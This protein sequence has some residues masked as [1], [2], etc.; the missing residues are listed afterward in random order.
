M[1]REIYVKLSMG[2]TTPIGKALGHIWYSNWALRD[3][4]PGINGYPHN[5]GE[6]SM[7]IT[8]TPDDCLAFMDLIGEKYPIARDDMNL[9]SAHVKAHP[10]KN[11]FEARKFFNELLHEKMS[12][13]RHFIDLS[14]GERNMFGA[15]VLHM[16]EIR[17]DLMAKAPNLRGYPHP[18]YG[19]MFVEGTGLE[20]HKFLDEFYAVYDDKDTGDAVADM[21]RALR[22]GQPVIRAYRY[23][24]PENYRPVFPDSYMFG[25][26]TQVYMVEEQFSFGHMISARDSFVGK[27]LWEVI[28]VE[29][30]AKNFTVYFVNE[31]AMAFTYKE[32]GFDFNEETDFAQDFS[33]AS[34][35]APEGE[36]LK[37]LQQHIRSYADRYDE[38]LVWFDEQI[39]QDPR[40]HK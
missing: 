9:F 25:K 34:R 38:K 26:F 40:Y 23:L 18:E 39:A 4:G 29:Y 30:T 28:G 22:D 15:N 16:Y 1:T 33:P 24:H 7:S 11:R 6:H 20:L 5:G 36:V 27:A 21:Q 14:S 2:Q 12:V 3:L 37:R 19:S 13:T 17:K 35:P 32:I 31:F 8:G 10:E